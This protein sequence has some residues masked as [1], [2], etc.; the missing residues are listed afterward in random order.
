MNMNNIREAY[1][2]IMQ[3][4]PH[5]QFTNRRGKEKKEVLGNE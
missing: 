1:I 2:G 3:R 5:L 4:S